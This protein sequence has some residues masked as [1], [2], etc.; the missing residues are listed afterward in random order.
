M[1][2]LVTSDAA[3]SNISKP[4]TGHDPGSQAAANMTGLVYL[5]CLD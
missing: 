5:L 1:T 2:P 3:S 4:E